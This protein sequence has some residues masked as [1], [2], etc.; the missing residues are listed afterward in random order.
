[1]GTV[2][3][4]L[5]CQVALDGV[6]YWIEPRGYRARRPRLRKATVTAGGG[7]VYV[8]AG[9][10]KRV[11][12]FTVLALNGLTRYDGR[13]TGLSGS[14]YRDA[15]AAAYAKIGP[16]PFVDPRGAAWNVHVDDLVETLPDGRVG[17]DAP[18]YLLRV[19]LVEA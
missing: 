16:L 12:T 14:D 3:V 15:L 18:A 19:E 1:M 4:G 17:L 10:G 13:P 2:N 11:W 8:D 9:P 7:E 6:G 5:D